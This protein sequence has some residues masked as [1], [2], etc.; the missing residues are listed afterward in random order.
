MMWSDGCR[1]QEER[2]LIGT[3]S[4]HHRQMLVQSEVGSDESVTKEGRRSSKLRSGSTKLP[5]SERQ[6]FGSM[7]KLSKLGV[8]CDNATLGRR[9][10][11]RFVTSIYKTLPF[12][13]VE[14][15]TFA[16]KTE[17]QGAALDTYE[18]VGA[19]AELV[20]G[21]KPA[22]RAG[23]AGP[24]RRHLAIVDRSPFR[25]DCLKLALGQ[26][27]RRWRVTDVE[28][29]GDLVRLLRQGTEFSVILLG[30][31]SCRQIELVD[32]AVLTAAAPQTPILALAD[33][34]N[35]ERARTILSSGARGFLPMSL[36]LKVLVAALERIRIGGTFVPLMLNE[37][38]GY[39]TRREVERPLPQV[40]TRRQRDVLA[41]ISEGRS[42][43]LIADAL[44]MSESTV[45]AHV[46]QIIRRLHV[47]NRTQAALVATRV[48]RQDTF[49]RAPVSAEVL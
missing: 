48:G 21:L 44:G 26:Q 11:L 9:C 13:L 19:I 22:E 14:R 28:T 38:N 34:D 20:T 46:K 12:S 43:K 25:R 8:G 24:C 27:P 7:Y 35:T 4:R 33:C 37:A 23:F 32:L 17:A 42:N 15:R 5:E 18:P 41:L 2:V 39:E 47:V 49:T 29:A 10:Y 3:G 6:I 40:L 31:A 45:K 36:G 16:E 30:A 1:F